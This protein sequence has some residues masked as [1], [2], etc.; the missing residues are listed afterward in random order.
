MFIKLSYKIKIVSGSQFPSWGS[1]L[2]TTATTMTF[3]SVSSSLE[4]VT[5]T[6]KREWKQGF[7]PNQVH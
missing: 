5:K 6:V 2:L 1:Q 7:H 3:Y 4:L